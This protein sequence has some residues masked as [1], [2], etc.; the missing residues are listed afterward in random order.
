[1]VTSLNPNDYAMPDSA[2]PWAGIVVGFASWILQV[3]ACLVVLSQVCNQGS[4]VST[5]ARLILCAITVVCAA[6]S[7]VGWTVSLRALRSQSS[8]RSIESFEAISRPRYT[9]LLGLFTSLIVTFSIALTCV[10]IF[11]LTMCGATR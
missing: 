5:H 2:R 3:A 9:A 7:V 6:A 4:L 10:P 8:E 11:V 1:M